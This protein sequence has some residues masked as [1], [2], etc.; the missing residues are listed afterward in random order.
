[1]PIKLFD[2][3]NR[4]EYY[5]QVPWDRRLS[6][7]NVSNTFT[8]DENSKTFYIN[9]T[10]PYSGNLYIDHIKH[11]DSIDLEDD[12]TIIWSEFPSIYIP[13]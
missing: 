13:L 3:D 1:M 4:I 10:I 8:F 12:T 6:F 5:R 7:K 11:T 2:G 9:G